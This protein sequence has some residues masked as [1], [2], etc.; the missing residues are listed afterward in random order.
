MPIAWIYGFGCRRGEGDEPEE[1][2]VIISS[3]QLS[4]HEASWPHPTIHACSLLNEWCFLQL[5]PVCQPLMTGCP[6]TKYI[7]LPPYPVCG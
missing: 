2:L 6:L 4:W 7:A 1:E 3:R 5:W